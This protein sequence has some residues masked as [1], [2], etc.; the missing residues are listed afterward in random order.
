MGVAQT[1]IR[2]RKGQMDLNTVAANVLELLAAEGVSLSDDLSDV[3]SK[4][5]EVVLRVGA[6]GDR[7]APVGQAPGLRGQQP[8]LR[9]SALR[10]RPEVRRPPP[11][12]AGDAAGTGDD[13]AG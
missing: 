7:G 10:A 12:H 5:R 2:P 9:R 3:E 1:T 6:R 8:D 13:P 11:A 4:V